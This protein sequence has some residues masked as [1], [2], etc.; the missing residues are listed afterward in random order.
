MSDADAVGYI[1]I[2]GKTR[3]YAVGRAHGSMVQVQRAVND[4]FPYKR[5]K[6]ETDDVS[7]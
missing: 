5:N 2:D 3:P 1:T 4:W 6:G 7:A